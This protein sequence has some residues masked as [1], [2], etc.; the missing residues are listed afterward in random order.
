MGK[1]AHQKK[2]IAQRN[3]DNLP[4]GGSKY[5]NSESPQIEDE[6]A[7]EASGTNFWSSSDTFLCSCKT[8]DIGSDRE[9]NIETEVKRLVDKIKDQQDLFNKRE[10][11]FKEEV[12]ILKSQL[13]EG[14]KV[15]K[16]YKE[17][18]YQCQ[19]LQDEVTS[20]INEVNE[21]STII[22]RLKDRSR[23]YE[24][25]EAKIISL[26]ED[27]ENSNN[28]NEELPQADE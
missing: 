3:R 21:K 24:S 23:Y 5:S 16:Q 28:Q 2:K 11:A 4:L 10:C 8:G 14:N 9:R 15:R 25:L 17:K 27:P 7:N 13:E 18:E 20:F 26:K 1:K 19:N 12:T 6:Q 22:K